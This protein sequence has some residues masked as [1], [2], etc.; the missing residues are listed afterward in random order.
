VGDVSWPSR[1]VQLRLAAIGVVVAVA[2]VLIVVAVSRGAS[3]PAA[4]TRPPSGSATSG[5]SAGGGSTTASSGTASPMPM[6]HHAAS[7]GAKPCTEVTVL[8][9]LEN[10]GMIGALA[11]AYD[12]VPRD[13]DG[14]CVHIQVR[15]EMSGVAL[16]QAQSGFTSQ[17][18]DQ[19]PDVWLPDSSAWLRLAQPSGV[20]PSSGTSIGQSAVVVAMPVELAMALGWIDKAPTWAD[21]F[22]AAEN[23]A[24]W[25]KLGH[26]S[27]GTFKIGKASPELA[28]SGLMSLLASYRSAD[29]DPAALTPADVDSAQAQHAVADSE[30]P[31][32]HYMSAPAQ[33]LFHAREAEQ[34]GSIATY[35]SAMFMDEKTVWDYN[36]GLMPTMQ[37]MGMTGPSM[38][39]MGGSGTM[40]GGTM[41]GGNG[42]LDP[43]K[44]RLVAIYPSDGVYVADNP[45]AVV[46]GSWV[47][48]AQAAAAADFIRFATTAQGQQVVRDNGYRDIHGQAAVQVSKV[49]LTVSRLH[50]LPLPSAATLTAV[51]HSFPVVRKRARVLFLLDVSGSM[52]NEIRPGLTK[53]AAAKHAVADALKYFNGTDRIGLAAFSNRPGGGLTPG[54]VS[55]VQPLSAGRQHFL[56]ALRALRPVSETPL[57]DAV[58]H[59]VTQLADNYRSQDIN[60]VV[61][62]SDG[63]NNTGRAGSKAQ[64]LQTLQRVPILVFT[65]GYGHQSD[66]RTLAAISSATGAHYY[67]A[68]DP[69]KVNQVLADDLVTSF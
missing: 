67:D 8:G 54:Q 11:D 23:P 60:A 20:V 48:P 57:Y 55:P 58:G 43:P 7:A 27:W 41:S 40:S 22:T 15:S 34:R 35:L 62:L 21:V 1:S 28:T 66:T 69:N 6:D 19:R 9:S 30:L 14:H 26:A 5:S 32:A 18:T 46:H 49:A 68:T 44:E 2:V 17:M 47:S 39:G 24:T 53:L 37:D 61:L 45:A 13:I 36:R 12:M 3:A 52:S 29:H 42:K 31:T 4:S 33:F 25:S 38:P 50:P 51:E 63:H 56:A 64:L 10:A 65:L 59:F 16:Q